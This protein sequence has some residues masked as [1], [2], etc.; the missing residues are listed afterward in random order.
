VSL[1]KLAELAAAGHSDD[2]RRHGQLLHDEDLSAV[3]GFARKPE[4]KP[5]SAVPES[6]ILRIQAYV[7]DPK[8]IRFRTV[9]ARFRGSENIASENPESGGWHL[10]V[11]Q[12]GGA[13]SSPLLGFLSVFLIQRTSGAP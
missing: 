7:R 6:V 3:L 13:K 4:Q 9:S 5:T 12:C 10:K 8:E 1:L 11:V 2:S